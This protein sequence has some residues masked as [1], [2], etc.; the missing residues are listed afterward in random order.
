LPGSL[1]A[2]RTITLTLPG[3]ATWKFDSSYNVVDPPTISATDSDA[4]GISLGSWQRVDDQTIKCTVSSTSAGASKPGKLVLEKAHIAI[5]AGA[6]TGDLKLVVGG[7]TGVT[8]EV[9]VG[10][11]TKTAKISV[12]G[13]VPEVA[14]GTQN[15]ELPPII[16]EEEA[17]E[18]IDG[19][20]VTSTDN[21]VASLGATGSYK[22][23]RLEFMQDIIPSQPTNVEVVAGDIDIDP[24]LVG[25]TASADGRW[26]IDIPIKGTSRT[27]SKIKVSGVKLSIY[28]GYPA[29]PVMCYLKGN[30]VVQTTKWFPGYTA[31]ASAP[32]ANIV[33]AAAREGAVAK[34]AT[35]RIGSTIYN[36]GAEARAMDVAPYIKDDRTFVPVRYLAYAL[37]V[38]ESDVKWDAA[39]QTVTLTKD[40]TTV[41]LVIGSN[42]LTVNDQVKQMDVAPEIVEPGRTMLP[43]RWVAEAFGAMVGWDPATQTVL[44]QW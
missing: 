6:P 12:D 44:I 17:A 36:V 2:G 25:R 27:P 22:V 8:G 28:A 7:T 37:G 32:V 5:S 3:Y 41:K 13:T 35:F 30:A 14:V 20:K 10:Q 34:S 24:A 11:V 38:K 16:I 39:T 19:G 33:T 43:A 29:G 26:G 15:V 18:G 31:V 21:T 1:I 9:V 40:R 23:V 4:Q 42:V